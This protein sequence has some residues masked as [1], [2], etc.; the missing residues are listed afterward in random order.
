MAKASTA[1][2]RGTTGVAKDGVELKHLGLY[3]QAEE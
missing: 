1:D 2:P 3:H